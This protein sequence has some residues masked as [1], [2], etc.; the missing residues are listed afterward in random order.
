M[1]NNNKGQPDIKKEKEKEKDKRWK[2][3][4]VNVW[5]R[6]EFEGIS[7][8]CLLCRDKNV[9]RKWNG[10]KPKLSQ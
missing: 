1:V 9:K 5:K 4:S 2:N 10:F 7:L 8:V 6:N 3:E